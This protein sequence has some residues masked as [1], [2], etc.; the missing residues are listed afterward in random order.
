[1]QEGQ[2]CTKSVVS[3]SGRSQL[4]ISLLDLLIYTFSPSIIEDNDWPNALLLLIPYFHKFFK[5]Q[6]CFKII[7][8]TNLKKQKQ[9]TGLGSFSLCNRKIKNVSTENPV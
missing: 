3:V 4:Q 6:T 7:S 2:Y 8:T 9:N 1:M 5:F